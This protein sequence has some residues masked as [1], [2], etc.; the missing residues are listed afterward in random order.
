MK[1][2][3]V[4][5]LYLLMMILVIH[6]HLFH[7]GDTLLEES[8]V[9][10]AMPLYASV[11]GVSWGAV[12]K[13]TR[14]CGVFSQ[15]KFFIYPYLFWTVV[16]VVLNYVFM[17]VM[18]RHQQFHFSINDALSAVFMAS[19]VVH[20]WFLVVLI[21]VMSIHILLYKYLA[22]KSLYIPLLLMVSVLSF[23]YYG[24]SFFE[25]SFPAWRFFGF[26]FLK[27]LSFFT[28]GMLFSIPKTKH[29]TENRTRWVVVPL[30]WGI[31]LTLY[32]CFPASLPIMVGVVLL[33]MITTP[34]LP[35]PRWL[36]AT[37]PYTMGIYMVHL[38]FTSFV[39]VIL[40]SMGNKVLSRPLAWAMSLCIY[41]A[42]WGTVYCARKLPLLRNVV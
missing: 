10:F 33:T 35:T 30:L 17:D 2:G 40:Q 25:G 24:A 4:A 1:S 21:Y 37:L 29:N 8:I 16:Y 18:I 3:W 19:G 27:V 36:K 42:C 39:N 13:K 15:L 22:D 20:T 38:M 5:W 12:L 31:G 14:G 11:A 7:V 6:T 23:V 41:F 26:Q 32:V 28:L 9:G 34:K